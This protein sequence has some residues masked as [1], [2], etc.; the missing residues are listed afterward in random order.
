MSF[1]FNITEGY[2]SLL[3]A[4]RGIDI[5]QLVLIVVPSVVL[6]AVCII[7]LFLSKSINLQMRV[8]L[9]NILAPGLVFNLGSIIL[10]V[11]NAAIV[12]GV[13]VMCKFAIIC[14]GV[15]N[16]VKTQAVNIYAIMTHRFIKQGIVKLKWKIIAAA[17]VIT[18]AITSLIN[19]GTALG[20]RLRED[21]FCE[22][23]PTSSG[24]RV[25]TRVLKFI[26]IVISLTLLVILTALVHRY[27]SKNVIS[28]DRSVKKALAKYLVYLLLENIA[29]LVLFFFST[30]V[31]AI[32]ATTHAVIIIAPALLEV[33]N[34]LPLLTTPIAMMVLILKPLRTFCGLITLRKGK[35]RADGQE[36][37]LESSVHQE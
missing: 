30:T 26:Q 11:G 22:L 12:S 32:S 27:K 25:A 18:W 1:N 23:D 4:T 20:S 5:V 37:R 14:I 15:G 24:I 35:G 8:I 36:M 13:P 29:L 7:R 16:G 3:A 9:I 31:N 2:D 19:L 21:T 17:I 10:L 34:G 6:S 28:E 33:A